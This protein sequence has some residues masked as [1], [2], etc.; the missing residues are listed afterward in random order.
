[1]K[2]RKKVN[3]TNWLHATALNQKLLA[4]YLNWP[5]MS[6]KYFSSKKK[7]GSLNFKKSKPLKILHLALGAL[8]QKL[9][10]FIKNIIVWVAKYF[11]KK[12][13]FSFSYF[14]K[15]HLQKEGPF[16]YRSPWS[17]VISDFFLIYLLWAGKHIFWSEIRSL[18]RKVN[19]IIICKNVLYVALGVRNQKLWDYYRN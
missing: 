8:N 10:H 15:N 16:G 13:D 5:T 9:Q 7:I 2:L 19:K 3:W 18:P 1:M 6:C 17:K 11:G 14:K 12:S 4:F